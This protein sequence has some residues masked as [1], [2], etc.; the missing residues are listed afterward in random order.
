MLVELVVAVLVL[1]VGLLALAGTAAAVSRM[2]A[3]G[4]RLGG[5]AVA[6]QS[7]LEE[8]RSGGCAA[9]GGG[10]DSVGHYRLQ[11]SVAATGS[12]RTVELTV[13]YP[14]GRGDRS[15][16]FEAVAWCP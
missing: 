11:W 16:R 12:L 8:L 5:S 14:D 3:W 13:G 6:A 15:D 2:V 4:Q 1:A 10:R 7:R 9:L